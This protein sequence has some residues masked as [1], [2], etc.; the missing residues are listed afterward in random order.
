MRART[1]IL[2]NQQNDI[3]RESSSPEPVVRPSGRGLPRSPR[4]PRRWTWRFRMPSQHPMTLR[5]HT[6]GIAATAAARSVLAGVQPPSRRTKVQ[7]PRVRRKESPV[8][9]VLPSPHPAPAK[10]TGTL[11]RHILILKEVAD[12]E[13]E[14]EAGRVLG[15]PVTPVRPA[16]R[17]RFLDL[18]ETR[19]VEVFEDTE[20]QDTL[21]ALTPVLYSGSS[22]N[23]ENDRNNLNVLEPEEEPAP[24]S[25]DV[26]TPPRNNH[27]DWSVLEAGPRDV[28]G[29]PFNFPTPLP[30]TTITT[31]VAETADI[32]N[33]PPRPNLQRTVW[34]GDDETG[35]ERY[36]TNSEIAV[37]E[38]LETGYFDRVPNN[39]QQIPVRGGQ[40]QA[41]TQA[42]PIP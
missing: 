36:E 27:L 38:L 9:V 28:F 5:S 4:L 12:T 8:I 20:S 7:T 34:P 24:P 6:R 37:R 39:A 17:A 22:E 29:L 32:T 18:S 14:N 15:N 10:R 31:V 19:K 25:S 21:E 11:H 42:A 23:K 3:I 35:D 16:G 2:K 26:D 40:A 30:D 13:T 33:P 41:Q 1:L